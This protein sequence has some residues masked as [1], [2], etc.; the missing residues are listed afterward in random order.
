MQILDNIAIDADREKGRLYF[1]GC[2]KFFNGLQTIMDM[3][4]DRVQE[5]GA[6]AMYYQNIAQIWGIILLL[7]VMLISPMLVVLARNAIFSMQVN[8]S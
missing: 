5:L 4:T 1:D 8:M 2:M 7:I 3:L 6:I